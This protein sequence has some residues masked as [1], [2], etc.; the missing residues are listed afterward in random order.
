VLIA[1]RGLAHF[2]RISSRLPRPPHHLDLAA[3]FDDDR[4]AKHLMRRIAMRF[5]A[6]PSIIASKSQI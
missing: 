1:R 2:A 3:G 5:V 6:R 4:H